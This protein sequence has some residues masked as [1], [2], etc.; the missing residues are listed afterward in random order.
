MTPVTLL[1]FVIT[2]ALLLVNSAEADTEGLDDSYRV[3]RVIF[4]GVYGVPKK[5]L[6]RILE[7]KSTPVWRP[8]KVPKVITHETIKDD[9]VRI[10][11]FYRDKG[12]YETIVAYTL[13]VKR[14][15]GVTKQVRDILPPSTNKTEQPK[16]ADI[17]FSVTEGDPVIISDIQV[18]L[19][20]GAPVN[21]SEVSVVDLP[22]HS[23]KPFEIDL[24][25][26]AKHLL[27]RRFGNIGHPFPQVDGDVIIDLKDG[28]ASISI[29]I[30][31]GPKCTYGPITLT[32]DKD[33]VKEVIIYRALEFKEG[34][35]YSEQA[36]DASQRNLFN[37]DVF[38][39]AIILTEK[40]ADDKNR[41]PVQLKLKAR[42]N[43]SIDLG[44]GYGNEDGPRLRGVWTYR[45]LF[46]SAAKLSLKVKHSNIVESTELEFKQPYWRDS[47]S[48]LV[49]TTGFLRDRLVAHQTSKLFFTADSRQ[50][51][52]RNS[53][54]S[55]GYIV[56]SSKLEDIDVTDPEELQ[57]F[58]KENDFFISAIRGGFA[59]DNRDNELNPH[60]GAI[61]T[62]SAEHAS[63]AYGSEIDYL[64]LGADF[65]RHIPVAKSV[66][67]SGRVHAQTVIDTEDTTEIPI[68][69]R[70]FLGGGTSVRGYGFQK[71]G[72]LDID[73]NP[74]GGQ[75]ALGANIELRYPIY[76]N[77][78]GVVFVDAGSVLQDAFEYNSNDV[79]F[80][81]GTGLR[82]DTRVG[83]IRL[84]WGYKL[85]PPTK[86][87]FGNTTDPDGEIERRWKIHI[88]IGQAF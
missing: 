28:T 86:G 23:G 42:N 50:R 60:S 13:E 2:S 31:P 26:E 66:T 39:P 85:N 64:K 55:I 27:N 35:T 88:S 63:I 20:S 48:E 22:I 83:P 80:S 30:E 47:A 58:Q 75:T 57:F 8:W 38:R 65:T 76:S 43:N 1:F 46:H 4:D 79:R 77:V 25:Q 6:R 61:L 82:Y 54:W 17:V 71:L 10:R 12:Y 41:V 78:S 34:D 21:S 14:T 56:E 49:M 69:K 11:R 73:G 9:M 68:F 5:T 24:Y 36:L 15:P 33:H 29:E 84:D 16:W 87:D 7:S 45:N 51:L 67:L 59:F 32:G 70:L 74:L 18:K 19:A 53:R 37:L 40:E 81:V 44:T 62:L 72:P 52:T 3:R